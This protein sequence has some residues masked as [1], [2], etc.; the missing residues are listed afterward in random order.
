MSLESLRHRRRR[1]YLFGA[2]LLLAGVVGATSFSLYRMRA[3]ALAREL[4]IA[5]FHA[6]SIED[7]LTQSL[8]VVDLTLAGVGELSEGVPA[9]SVS[10]AFRQALRTAPYLRSISLLDD[11]GRIVASST[12]GNVGVTPV[13]DDYFPR[14]PGRSEVLQVGAAVA[15]R[16]FLEAGANGAG[17][18][19]TLFVPLARQVRRA[20]STATLMAALNVDYYANHYLATVPPSAG[21]V[22]ILRYD[23]LPL[24]TTDDGGRGEL[25]GR[26]D[27]IQGRLARSEIGQFE[28]ALAGGA[29][30]LTAYR[31]SRHY[32]FVVVVRLDKST[33]LGDWQQQARTTLVLV[34]IA[35][36][37]MGLALVFAFVRGRRA[38]RDQL[39]AL[40]QQRLS[41]SVFDSSLEAIVI[42]DPEASILSVNPAFSVITGYRAE[43]VVG[44]NSRLLASGQHDAAFYRQF[45]AAL[46]ETGR[47][48]GEITNR[49]KDGSVYTEWLV[50]TR[51]TDEAGRCINYVGVFSDITEKKR[52]EKELRLAAATFE[53]Q[54]GVMI[55]D[56]SGR[57]IRVNRAFTETTGYSAD[58]AIGQ[59]P[60]LLQS[61]RHGREFYAAMWAAVASHGSWQ[62][63][64]WNKRKSGEVYPEWLTISAVRAGDGTVSHYVATFSDI[65]RQKEAEDEIKLLAF[66]DALTGLPNRRLLT[67]RLRQTVKAGRRLRYTGALLFIDL[68]HFKDLNDTLGHEFGDMMLVQVA[69]RLGRTVREGDTVARLGGDEFVILLQGL[70]DQPELAAAQ[71]GAVAE[72]ILQS[73]IAPFDL[74]GQEYHSSP[75]IGVTLFGGGDHLGEEVIKR[76]DVAMYQAKASGRNR[77][78]FFD[79]VMQAAIEAR[80]RMVE[81]LR[82]AIATGQLVLHYQIQ[83]NRDGLPIGAEALVRWQHPVRGL[84]MPAEFV[85]L[86]E[87][88]G[89]I[90]ALGEWV[91][92]AACR[93]LLRWQ[94]DPGTRQLALAIN[95]SARQF[96]HDDFVPRVLS[97]VLSS[98]IKPDRLKL[99]LT[100]SVLVSDIDQAVAKMAQLRLHGIRFALDDFGTGYSSLSYLKRLPIDQI[101]IDQSFVRDILSDE[102]DAAIVRTILALGKTL[103]LDVIAE[104]VE[105]EP[106]YRAL[107]D[108]GCAAFQGYLFGRPCPAEDIG[109][110]R[111]PMG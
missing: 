11:Q 88:S 83:V 90:L 82:Q 66:Y 108:A 64:I 3:N 52:A 35:L 13:R 42:T 65:S 28:E 26:F 73:F 104:G 9:S 59:T 7:H 62:G 69:T 78:C 111:A 36:G 96:H 4:D 98:G 27:D 102:N 10:A 86:A 19:L 51:V 30:S 74:G 24:L 105:L 103:G 101:K 80:L 107:L 49:R 97:R 43:E 20:S 6:R 93:Q 79:P 57:I 56:L 50:V 37:A 53:T 106:Q 17:P 48:Q 25:A 67:E 46:T 23:G 8:N 40:E 76:A 84:V 71:A 75:S 70:N 16:D 2:V 22:A 47:W 61:G 100:E 12:P 63:E 34:G 109:R 39:R 95:V 15:G 99:E 21:V 45:W 60:R 92:E 110:G 14:D 38:D 68:D 41:A 1:S 94:D 87:D 18:A 72:K 5:A 29:R 91:L 31:A 33:A 44:R 55:T 58:E 54:E 81:E 77:V 85:S 32:P 89:Q